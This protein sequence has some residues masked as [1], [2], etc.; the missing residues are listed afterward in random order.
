MTADPGIIGTDAQTLNQEFPAFHAF[1]AGSGRWF[2]YRKDPLTPA[3]R[4]FGCVGVLKADDGAELR[5]LLNGQADCD[6]RA[7]HVHVA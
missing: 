6:W 7:S 3:Q 2:A 5:R 1:V 4:L